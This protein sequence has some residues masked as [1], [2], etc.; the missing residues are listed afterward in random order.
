MPPQA[1]KKSHKG[2]K[3]AKK[4][5]AKKAKGGKAGKAK[6]AAPPPPPPAPAPAPPPAAPLPHNSPFALP[7]TNRVTKNNAKRMFCLTE[8]DFRGM[9][10]IFQG[11]SYKMY[12]LKD[13]KSVC[14]ERW[15]SPQ[16][17]ATELQERRDK[18]MDM[19]GDIFF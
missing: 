3:P 11:T 15:G 9:S 16:G 8:K 19:F 6:G 14:L 2:E 13:L 12:E 7:D 10:Y 4:A 17:L 5:V 18:F 1:A